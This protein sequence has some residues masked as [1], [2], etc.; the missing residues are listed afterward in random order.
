MKFIIDHS[1]QKAHHSQHSDSIFIPT[2]SLLNSIIFFQIRFFQFCFNSL[3]I[4]R[5]SFKRILLIWY[6]F[7]NQMVFFAWIFHNL[8]FFIL[9]IEWWLSV[10]ILISIV[11]LLIDAGFLWSL[12]LNGCRL[13]LKH[14]FKIYVFISIKI[15]NYINLILYNI[16]FSL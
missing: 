16:Y 6:M 3:K 7:L 1:C 14:V 8:I 9:W 5:F 4:Q 12:R 2:P 11:I 13:I 10:R 15:V